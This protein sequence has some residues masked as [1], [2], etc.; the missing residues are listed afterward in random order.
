MTHKMPTPRTLT[1]QPHS[2]RLW[3]RIRFAGIHKAP[4]PGAWMRD[5][6]VWTLRGLPWYAS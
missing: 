1:V 5:S 6:V 2:I 3:L 4:P